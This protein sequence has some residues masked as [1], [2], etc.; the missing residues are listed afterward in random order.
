MRLAL[1]MDLNHTNTVSDPAYQ[2]MLKRYTVNKGTK[3]NTLNL[4]R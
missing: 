2:V 3:T 4:S 1:N